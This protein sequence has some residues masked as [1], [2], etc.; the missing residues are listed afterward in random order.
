MPGHI[1]APVVINCAGLVKQR[2]YHAS[3]VY[4]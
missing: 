1:H 2:H 3:A 4:D